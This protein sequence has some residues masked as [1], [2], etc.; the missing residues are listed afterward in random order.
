ML[1]G[2]FKLFAQ[3]TKVDEAKRLVYGRA[4][5]EVPDGSREIIDI[6]K[7]WPRFEKWSQAAEKRS[8]GKS[9][10]NIREMHEAIAAGK[11]IEMQKVDTEDGHLAIDIGTYCSDDSTW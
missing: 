1:D 7:S 2:E 10:G 8:G 4:T 6:T 9:K 5:E 11:L 3:L